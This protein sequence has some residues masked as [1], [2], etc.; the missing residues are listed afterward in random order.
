MHELTYCPWNKGPKGTHEGASGPETIP[1]I[2][3]AGLIPLLCAGF[4]CASL[5]EF[6]HKRGA[7]DHVHIFFSRETDLLLLS[8]QPGELFWSPCLHIPVVL[9]ASFRV[10]SVMLGKYSIFPR[11]K[12]Q[13]NSGLSQNSSFGFCFG[14]VFFLF[15]DSS[16]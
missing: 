12:H 13:C 4:A 7:S 9:S 5:N 3:C 11:E 15:P 6:M 2:M 14:S 8:T 16:F 10:V 1:C